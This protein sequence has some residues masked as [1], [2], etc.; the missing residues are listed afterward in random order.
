M[1]ILVTGGAGFIGSHVAECYLKNGFDVIILDNLSSGSKAYLP[2]GAVFYEGDIRDEHL[3]ESVFSA[4][5]P[6]VLNHH[7]AQI[8]L[9]V[10]MDNPAHD[11]ETNILG[12]LH[13][14][15]GAR[16]HGVKKII[17]A[18]SGGAVYG[19]TGSAAATEDQPP[20][21]ASAYGI[22]KLTF[23]RYLELFGKTYGI[24]YVVLRYSNVYGP[25]QNS[26][27]EGGVVGIFCR[28]Y[29][30]GLPLTIRGSGEQSR[31]FVFVEDVA[32][33]NLRAATLP[34]ENIIVNISTGIETSINVLAQHFV[35]LFSDE[36][37]KTQA[38]LSFPGD[39]L[40]SCL[41]CDQARFRIG[42]EPKT[43]LVEGIQKTL[44][45]YRQH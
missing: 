20:A 23:E 36:P 15:E 11:A 39:V 22:S 10:S 7:A 29:V 1:K 12:S 33:A 32:E 40:R 45:F 17:F 43:T 3:V 2:K 31:D 35:D 44:D 9:A 26:S 16:K 38:T 8:N 37:V 13:L 25:R 42:W 5:K 34:A 19:Q 21:P 6:D 28:Q 18:S 27:G 41:N 24:G 14:L 30:N 4:E